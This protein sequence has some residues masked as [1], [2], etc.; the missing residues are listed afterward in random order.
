MCQRLHG[1]LE[2]LDQQFVGELFFRSGPAVAQGAYLI[3]KRDADFM[4]LSDRA[5][6]ASTYGKGENDC[7][8]YDVALGRQ[9]EKEHSLDTFPASH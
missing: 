6:V 2:R 4:V 8:F 9:M 3:Q 7:C 5:K 1:M